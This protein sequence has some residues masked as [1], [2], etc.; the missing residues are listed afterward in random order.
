MV[1]CSFCGK[2]VEGLPHKCKFCGK[3]HCPKHLLPESH[4]CVGLEKYK[5][6]SLKKWKSAFS[7]KKHKKPTIPRKTK[8]YFTYK[9]EDFRNWLRY[10]EHYRY[11]F[12]NRTNYLIK[13]IL[14]FIVS[15]IGF[16]IFYFNAQK[17][18]EINLWII[19]L[20]GVLIL[21]SLFF[22][23]KYGWKI[24]KEIINVLKRQKNWL[25]YLIIILIIILLWQIYTHKDTVLNPVF[26]VYNKTNFSLFSPLD[27]GDFGLG[28]NKNSSDS[29][30]GL[31]NID[32]NRNVETIEQEILIL[33][34]EERQRYGIRVLTSESNL[35]SFARSWSERMI[36]QNF[37]EHSNL[38]FSY[39]STAGE[40]IGEVPIHYNVIGCGSTYSNSQ[41]AKCFVSGWISSPGHHENMI[42]RSFS[43]TG[44]GVACDLSKCRA[45]QVFSG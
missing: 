43:M 5:E 2:S 30:G 7:I 36:S 34:N 28:N 22:I 10:R 16:N 13:I 14:I 1:K 9:F 38:G 35:N 41:I 8:G 44:I 4:N 6:K 21:L 24:I 25:K 32:S 23:I 42:D 17:L 27:L 26:E 29:G 11:D 39:P 40:N 20:G 37:F 33:V 15:I 19:K 12:R 3:I 31:F 45:T 18:N